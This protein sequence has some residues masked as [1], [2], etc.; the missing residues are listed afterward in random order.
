MGVDGYAN[1]EETLPQVT[2]L[3]N[4]MMRLLLDEGVNVDD[5]VKRG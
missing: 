3:L 1:L 4:E 5:L 2:W